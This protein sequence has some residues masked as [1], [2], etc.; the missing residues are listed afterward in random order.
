MPSRSAL[1]AACS[2]RLTTSKTDGVVPVDALEEISGGVGSGDGASGGVATSGCVFGDADVDPG[3]VVRG[4]KD[5]LKRDFKDLGDDDLVELVD[6][7]GDL[8]L[9]C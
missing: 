5:L 7:L 8:A 6:T 9:R 2:Y 1:L 4:D 3:L